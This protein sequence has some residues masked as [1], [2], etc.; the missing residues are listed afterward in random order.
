MVVPDKLQQQFFE[1]A[2]DLYKTKSAEDPF[3]AKVYQSQLDF[4]TEYKRF[5]NYQTPKF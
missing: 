4:L 2:D 1:I 5:E 3:F